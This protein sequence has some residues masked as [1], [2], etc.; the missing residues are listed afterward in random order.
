MLPINDLSKIIFIDI[1]TVP[2][3]Y[4]FNELDDR[5]QELWNKCLLFSDLLAVNYLKL[6]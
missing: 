2:V 5:G 6:P 4:N 1:E 3:V